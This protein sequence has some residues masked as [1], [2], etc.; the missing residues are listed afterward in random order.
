MMRSTIK[1]LSILLLV[2]LSTSAW[3]VRQPSGETIPVADRDQHLDCNAIVPL[4]IGD[5]V[6][7]DNSGIPNG[8][9]LYSCQSWDMWGG[10]DLYEVTVTEAGTYLVSLVSDCDLGIMLLD[11]CY[12]M[13]TCLGFSDEYTAGMEWFSV[14]LT[15]GTYVLVVD[16]FWYDEGCPYELTVS[17]E[18]DPDT[19]IHRLGTNRCDDVPLVCLEPAIEER[20]VLSSTD[21]AFGFNNDYQIGPACSYNCCYVSKDAVFAVALNDGNQIIVTLWTDNMTVYVTDNCELESCL[22]GTNTAF[23]GNAP[24]S[25]TYTHSGEYKLVYLVFEAVYDSI[26]TFH[27]SYTHDGD[28]ALAV[29]NEDASWGAVK[30][31]YR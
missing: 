16:G 1:L 6:Y 13:S 2:M 17:V 15:P 27:F 24:R 19:S 26:R 10:E 25:F 14:D 3:A 28:C 20:H 11:H 23:F 22:G 29:A 12:R 9:N 31:L 18:G 4:T 8:A 7:G 30:A 5:T 21:D